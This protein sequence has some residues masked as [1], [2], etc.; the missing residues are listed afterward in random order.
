MVEGEVAVAGAGGT[1]TRLVGNIATSG[2]PLHPFGVPLPH[3]QERAE[4]EKDWLTVRALQRPKY[5]LS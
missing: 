4:E 1:K 3:A 2:S 5:R